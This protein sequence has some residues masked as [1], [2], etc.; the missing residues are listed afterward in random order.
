ML[1]Q[2]YRL[3]KSWLIKKVNRR[4]RKFREYCVGL[5]VLKQKK[6]V[7][8]KFAFVVPL[9]VSKR[10]VDR[11]LLKR[12]ASEVFLQRINDVSSGFDI[13]VRFGRGAADMSHDK[14]KKVIIKLLKKAGML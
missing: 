12:R 14:L 9:S 1:P 4:G 6:P 13:V 8:S 11:N 10:A 5:S 7:E 3:Q 2:R